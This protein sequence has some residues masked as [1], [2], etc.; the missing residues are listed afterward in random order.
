[1]EIVV[2][3]SAEADA[4]FAKMERCSRCGGSIEPT[5]LANDRRVLV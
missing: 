5:A 2:S 1:M 4:W 3:R